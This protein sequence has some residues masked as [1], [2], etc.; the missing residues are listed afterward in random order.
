VS[1]RRRWIGPLLFAVYTLAYAAFVFVAAF[2]SFEGGKPA[3]GLA[4]EAYAG[5]NWGVIAGFGLIVGAFL[6]AVVYALAGP[7]ATEDSEA[8]R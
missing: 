1:S 4:R 2:A 3:G 6:L 8:P 5:V 7:A